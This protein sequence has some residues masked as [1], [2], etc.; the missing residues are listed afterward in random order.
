MEDLLF[1]LVRSMN[2]LM[3]SKYNRLVSTLHYRVLRM[4][5]R[6]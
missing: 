6:V 2:E 5:C 1:E 3:S 4:A